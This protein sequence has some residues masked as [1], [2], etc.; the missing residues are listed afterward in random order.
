MDK[1][2]PF[3]E[4]NI[5]KTVVEN[6]MAEE[7][8]EERRKYRGYLFDEI[9]ELLI[10]SYVFGTDAANSMLDTDYPIL[11]KEVFSSLNKEIAGKD[12]KERVSEYLETGTAEDIMRVVTTDAHRIYNE[13]LWNVGQAAL[14]DGILVF[15][16]W[17]CMMLPTSRDTHVYLQGE[18]VPLGEDFYT[19]DGDYAPHPGAFMFPENNVNCLCRI[20]LTRA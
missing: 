7:N 11:E 4:L 19:Y 17:E 3:D 8:A 16:E 1:L 20:K 14:D 5:L 9:A 2:M 12:W 10:L 18:A 15:K 6:I 13:A